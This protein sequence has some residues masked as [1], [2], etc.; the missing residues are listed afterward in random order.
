MTVSLS[1]EAMLVVDGFMAA[2]EIPSR[3]AA[4]NALLERIGEDMFL[5]QEF[6]AVST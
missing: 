6:L 4:F 5:R 3:Q 1:P 2:K